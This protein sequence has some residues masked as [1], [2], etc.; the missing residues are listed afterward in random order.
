MKTSVNEKYENG[1]SKM[2]STVT[3]ESLHSF[4]TS[5]HSFIFIGLFR[6]TVLFSHCPQIAEASL[7]GKCLYKTKYTLQMVLNIY[8]QQK[9]FKLI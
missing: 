3:Y 4:K 1:I 5:I 2:Q 8:C 6:F 7:G 9:L